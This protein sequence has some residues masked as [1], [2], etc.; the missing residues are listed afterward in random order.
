MSKLK[1]DFIKATSNT[2]KSLRE[3]I[4]TIVQHASLYGGIFFVG[5]ACENPIGGIAITAGGLLLGE[6][7]KPKTKLKICKQQHI[8]YG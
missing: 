8:A 5:I 7:I 6:V 2:I 3:N 1:N 4:G